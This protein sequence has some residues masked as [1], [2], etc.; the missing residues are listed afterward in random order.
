MA[1]IMYL[2]KAPRYKNIM[3][4]KYETIS[5]NDIAL[6][7]KYFSWGMAR[8]EGGRYS[9]DTLEEW[10]GISESKLPHKYIVNYYRD[11]FTEKNAYG[12]MIGEY[13]RHTI[14]E[15]LA[16]IVKAN[17]IF[18]WFIN[19]VM[20]GVIDNEYYEVSKEQLSALLDTCKQVV[21]EGTIKESNAKEL[22][23]L[24]ENKG[25]FF[26]TSEYNNAYAIQVTT[27]I[28]ILES[29][30]NTTDFEKETVY[31]NATW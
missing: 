17:Q 13:K 9:C 25:Y 15:H 8:E 1:L 16:R 23:P 20:N 26:G 4:N 11:F 24:M 3:T 30:L 10:C 6:I 19:N 27:M 12:E 7:D 2:T 22:L 5:R 14:F 21:S 29:V 28:E 18:E 31:F